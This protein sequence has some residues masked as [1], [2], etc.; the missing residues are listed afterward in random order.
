MD[1]YMDPDEN[2]PFDMDFDP[3]IETLVHEVIYHLINALSHQDMTIGEL[4]IKD[5]EEVGQAVFIAAL[6]HGGVK[7][8][9]FRQFSACYR[10]ALLVS[11]GKT[12]LLMEEWS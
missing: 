6:E 7:P 10:Q 11:T 5:A 8:H 3:H 2:Q 9:D 4:A 12:N 1:A